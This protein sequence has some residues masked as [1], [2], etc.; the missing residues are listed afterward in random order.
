M[1][2]IVGKLILKAILP[3][4][5]ISFYFC[6]S[7]ICPK[8]QKPILTMLGKT[9]L[10]LLLLLTNA[11]PYKSSDDAETWRKRF[12]TCILILIKV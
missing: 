7:N 3:Q 1:R 11:I 2:I 6:S 9:T 4:N 12:I 5:F 8:T 10:E